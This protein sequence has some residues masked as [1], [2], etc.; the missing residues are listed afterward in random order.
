M[1]VRNLPPPAGKRS[2]YALSGNLRPARFL[3]IALLLVLAGPAVHAQLVAPDD[4]L[5]ADN[6]AR[7]YKDESMV[8]RSSYHYF[9]FDKGKNALDDKVVTVQEDAELEFLSIKKFATL[10]YP[11]YYNKF[12]QLKS[13]KKAVKYGNRYVTSERSGIDR[14]VTDDDVFFD[15]SRVQ[16]FPL[17]FAQKGVSTRI[18]VKKEYSDGKYLTRLFFR[19]P[20]PTEEQVFEFKVPDWLSIDFKTFNFDKSI[21]RRQTSK[22][23]Y[24]N[25]VFIMKNIP[26]YKS[27]FKQLG[28][29]YTDPHIVIQIKSFEAK[30]ETLQGFDKVADVYRWNNRLYNMAGN[31]REKLR[32]TLAK[33]TADRTTDLEKIK[34]IYYF[35]QDKIRYIAFEEGYSGY[36]PTAAQ[37]VLANKYGDCKGMAN[38]LTEMLKM[39]GFD[40]HFTWIGTREI[41]YPQS[42]PALC[43]NNHAIT[44]LYYQGKEYFLDATEKYVPF[45]ENA[46]RIQ[47]KEALIAKGDKFEIKAIPITTGN[48]HK[49]YTKA[50]FTLNNELLTGK[51][52]VTLTGNERKDFHQVYQDL[53]ISG[54]DKFLSSFLEF[55]NDNLEA[56]QITTSDL[57][58]REIPVVIS[59]TIGLNNHVQSIAGSKYVKLDFFP[60]TLQGYMPDE[61]RMSG[62]DLDYVLSYVDEFSLTIPAGSSF[63]D[64]PEKLN[65][66]ADGY[67]F[68]GEY[69]VNGNTIVLKKNMVLKK[70]VIDR[71]D[72]TE[73]TTFLNSIKEFNSYFFSVTSK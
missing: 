20:Y 68:H 37:T 35:V 3:L 47:G 29:A 51:V 19:S 56:S 12:I 28:R 5:D 55:N 64:V 13:F 44:T 45:G 63:S 33:V 17:R 70:S 43:V 30:G 49:V 50:S 42:L 2:A 62:Y 53:P 26:A 25:Y 10:T 73:W 41:P 11:E 65:L 22:G 54:R 52:Q 39:A 4:A 15:D 38:L 40:A 66:Q 6:L 24:T 32:E 8:C 57:T 7:K 16:Y 61:K 48:D 31:D 9:T 21:E 27:E 71:K 67:E 46:Y 60:K 18:T 59:G 23:G 1:P 34:A 36:I 14:S 58:N 72:F 69:I